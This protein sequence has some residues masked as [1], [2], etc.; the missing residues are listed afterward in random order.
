MFY[1]DDFHELHKDPSP[2]I[3]LDVRGSVPST[4]SAP[5]LESQ[6]DPPLVETSNTRMTSETIQLSHGQRANKTGSSQ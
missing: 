4:V 1:D 3:M 6:N 2:P 5:S